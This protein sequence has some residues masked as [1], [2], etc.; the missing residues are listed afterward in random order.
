MLDR[1]LQQGVSTI[2]PEI[3]T[4]VRREVPPAVRAEME[5]TLRRYNIT[6]ETGR[7]IASVINA[8]SASG[9]LSPS[10]AFR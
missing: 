6:P 7:Q 1:Q 2:A 10:G 3:A 5:A 9:L 4:A 8:L